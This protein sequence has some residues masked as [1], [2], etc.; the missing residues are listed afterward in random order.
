MIK[1]ID[2][3]QRFSVKLILIAIFIFTISNTFSQDKGYEIKVKIKNSSDTIMYLVNYYADK[4]YIQ[5][6]ADIDAKGF[7]T[8]KGKEALEGG[9]YLAVRQSRKYFEFLV[10]KEQHITFETDTVDMVK[11]MKIKGSPENKLF[12]EYLNFLTTKTN[13]STELT[14]LKQS[15]KNNEDSIKM[16]QEKLDNINKDVQNYKLDFISKHP[17]LFMSKIFLASKEPEIPEAPKPP[18]GQEKDSLYI[19]KF[20]YNYFKNHY[21]DGFDFSDDRL[22]RTPIFHYKLKRYW[23]TTLLQHPDT[24]IK[25]ADWMIAQTKGNK[26]TFKYVIWYTT[27]QSETSS[28]MGI[29]KVFVHLVETYYMTGKA[30]W[31]NE[32]VLENITKSAMKLKKLLIGVKAPDL[33]MMDTLGRFVPLHGVKAKF[34]V[35]YFWDTDCGHCKK[36]T[37]LLNEFYKNYKDKGVEVYSVATDKNVKRWT[38]FV[39]DNELHWLNVYDGKNWTNYK[40]I[41]DVIATPVLYLLDKDKIILAKKLSVEQLQDFVDRELEKEKAE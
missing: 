37:P 3:I 35:L 15:I 20:Q 19:Q 23:N 4:Q 5:D 36:E 27:Y 31:I 33:L 38:K 34:T 6:T 39:N 24:L 7:A 16:I 13:E 14:E 22:L 8:F 12:F 40:E 25:E 18:E 17:D 9:I 28:I 21:W 41:Y 11:N 10:D 1:I 2:M 32:K 30:H 26:E 29:D